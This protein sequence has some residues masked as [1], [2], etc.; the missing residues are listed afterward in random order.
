[1]TSYVFT[2]W[3]LAISAA[4]STGPGSPSSMASWHSASRPFIASQALPRGRLPTASN[5][6]SSA[7]IGSCALSLAFFRIARTSSFWTDFMILGAV[8]ANAFSA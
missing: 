8:L 1:M 2:P 6:R 3:M 5:T 7:S 4:S